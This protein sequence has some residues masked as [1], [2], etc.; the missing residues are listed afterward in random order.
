M[1]SHKPGAQ[2]CKEKEKCEENNRRALQKLFPVGFKSKT[3]AAK[4]TPNVDADET[5]PSLDLVKEVD[6]E[7]ANLEGK[8]G[9]QRK[10]FEKKV[11]VR[12]ERN[13]KPISTFTI[14]GE[15]KS[16]IREDI[17]LL[18][19]EV[20]SHFVVTCNILR[21][22]I[23]YTGC[24]KNTSHILLVEKKVKTNVIQKNIL[25]SLK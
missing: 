14:S 6:E 22:L 3:R 16:N 7:N 4:N 18:A 17:G 15:E 12:D 2:K 1:S 20:P 5:N 19:T 21:E 25:L 8:T 23:T 9:R 10:N 13:R 11:N 24:G